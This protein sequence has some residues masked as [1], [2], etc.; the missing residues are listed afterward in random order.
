M[1][2]HIY[3]QKRTSGAFIGAGALNR[4]NTVYNTEGNKFSNF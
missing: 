1:L 3:I 2:V 4:G